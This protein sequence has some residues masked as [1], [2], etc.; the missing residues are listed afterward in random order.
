MKTF[1]ITSLSVDECWQDTVVKVSLLD[2]T[3]EGSYYW[4]LQNPYPLVKSQPQRLSLGGVTERVTSGFSLSTWRIIL[5]LIWHGS[6][7]ISNK[8]VR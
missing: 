3:I 2:R 6:Y 4:S 8:D 5:L 1:Q 7:S